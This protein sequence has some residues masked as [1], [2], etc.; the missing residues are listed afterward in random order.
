MRILPAY[1]SITLKAGKKGCYSG[2]VKLLT[3]DLIAEEFG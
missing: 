3:W 2:L 1:E